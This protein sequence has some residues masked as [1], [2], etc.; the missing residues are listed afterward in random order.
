MTIMRQRSP[1]TMSFHPSDEGTDD[2]DV[3]LM[4]RIESYPGICVV[5][6]TRSIRYFNKDDPSEEVG[7][8]YYQILYRVSSLEKEGL[9]V[10]KKE[11]SKKGMER[12]CYPR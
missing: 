9:I 5:E 1:S 2:L 11:P 8:N 4:R 12:R 6:L 3:L 10:T 7:P